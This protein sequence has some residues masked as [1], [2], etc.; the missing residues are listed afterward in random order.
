MARAEVKE[1]AYIRADRVVPQKAAEK[2]KAEPPAPKVRTVTG[3]VRD[4]QG[5]PVSAVQV[6]VSPADPGPDPEFP[7]FDSRPPTAKGCSCSR[8]CRADRSRS[9]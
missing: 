5:R 8:N 4:P 7:Q 2:A 1:E 6:Q 9:P 3:H